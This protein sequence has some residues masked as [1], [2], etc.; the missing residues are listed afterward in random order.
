MLYVRVTR[1]KEGKV[2]LARVLTENEASA[3]HTIAEVESR[4]DWKTFEAAAEVAAELGP[5]YIATDA[6]HGV[7]PRYDVIELPK[8]GDKVSYA[9]NGDYY[10]CGEIASISKSLKLITT[11]EGRKFYRV[12]QTGCWKNAGTWSLV[13]GHVSK[14]NPE[15]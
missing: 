7:S 9:F 6:G 5:N 12:R 3:R 1:N 10:P 8:V 2:L 4:W 11:T 15:F 13:P 14:Q